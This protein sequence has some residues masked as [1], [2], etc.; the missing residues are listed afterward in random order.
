MQLN[1]ALLA[2]CAGIWAHAVRFALL[3]ALDIEFEDVLSDGAM[4]EAARARTAGLD[5][6]DVEDGDGGHGCVST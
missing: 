5:R 2:M 3:T 6:G 4:G 1:G